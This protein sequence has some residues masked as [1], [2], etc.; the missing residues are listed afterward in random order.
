MNSFCIIRRIGSFSLLRI[1]HFLLEGQI[2][3]WMNFDVWIGFSYLGASL[4]ANAL[5][6][7]YILLHVSTILMLVSFT[8]SHTLIMEFSL[9]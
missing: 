9:F 4:L 3:E 2:G 8:L 7:G 6:V 1:S 5:M